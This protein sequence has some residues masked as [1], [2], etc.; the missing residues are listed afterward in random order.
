MARFATRI[1]PIDRHPSV[2]P[3]SGHLYSC[4]GLW[5]GSPYLPDCWYCT[6]RPTETDRGKRQFGGSYEQAHSSTMLAPVSCLAAGYLSST[7]PQRETSRSPHGPLAIPCENCHNAASWRPIRA[8]PEFDHN[9]TKVSAPRHARKGAVRA[10]P[11]QASLYQRRQ[12]LPGLPRR[13]PPAKNGR[14][15]RAMPHRSRLEYRRPA[16]K[17]SPEIVF[18]CWRSRGRAVRRLPQ[19]RRGRPVSGPV[20]GMQLLPYARIFSK[21]RGPDHVA[22]QFPQTCDSCHSF[23]SWL[24]RQRKPLRASYQFS[25]LR[26]GTRMFPVELPRGQQLQFE[27]RGDGLRECRIAISQPGS[28]RRTPSIRGGHSISGCGVLHLP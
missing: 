9:K 23:D 24:G 15:L 12:E 8:V 11:Q 28:K 10:M 27:N 14:E 3:L 2:W 16:S 22:G 20:N 17:R 5:R 21:P 26:T 4:L 6:L 18:R 19:E 7:P 25:R 13:H 1:D